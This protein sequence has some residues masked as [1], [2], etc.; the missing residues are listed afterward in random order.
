M[1]TQ[2]VTIELPEPVFR[3][4]VRIAA[5]TQQSVE[6]LAAQRVVSNLPPSVENAPLEIQPELLKMQNLSIEKL[7]GIANTLVEPTQHQ[8]HLELLEKNKESLLAPEEQEE[9]T[10]LR[11]TADFLMLRKAY[12]W[13]ILRWRGHRLPPLKE[14]PV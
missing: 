8:R 13:S 12:A 11:L 7:L 5:A 3:Q 6:V 10:N 2:Q 1:T 9:L 14:L 4:L